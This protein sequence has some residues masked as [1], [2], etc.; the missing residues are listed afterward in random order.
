MTTFTR[1]GSLRPVSNNSIK[2]SELKPE[3][4]VVVGR[5]EGVEE[6]TNPK[7]G[8]KFD[9]LRFTDLEGKEIKINS[10]AAL[11]A[12]FPPERAGIK[13]EIIFLGKHK[14]KTAKGVVDKNEFSI[15]EIEAEIP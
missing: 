10:V 2:I 4:T 9:V 13:V 6:V 11:K 1:L 7:D 3:D 8:K 14:V 15:S 12:Y 5:F